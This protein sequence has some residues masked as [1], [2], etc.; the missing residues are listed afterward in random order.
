MIKGGIKIVQIEKVGD[1]SYRGFNYI[2][3]HFVPDNYPRLNGG[4]GEA[5][6]GWVVCQ[7][8]LFNPQPNYIRIKKNTPQTLAISNLGAGSERWTKVKYKFKF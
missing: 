2:Y 1:K 6:D 3:I 5:P 8:W 4:V 7:I